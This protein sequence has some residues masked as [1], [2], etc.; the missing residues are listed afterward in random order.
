MPR[1]CR[2]VQPEASKRS[3][4]IC[5]K[6]GLDY[7]HFRN[8]VFRISVQHHYGRYANNFY[9]VRYEFL[10]VLAMTVTQSS[11]DMT[12]CSIADLYGSLDECAVYIFRTEESTTT[13]P[14]VSTLTMEAARSPK[15]TLSIYQTHYMTSQKTVIFNYYFKHNYIH[16][17]HKL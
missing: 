5:S 14:Y 11:Y 15:I 13:T 10:A 12:Q 2:F 8:R 3:E 7:I 6:S 16:I 1:A 9:F 4:Y 17:Q